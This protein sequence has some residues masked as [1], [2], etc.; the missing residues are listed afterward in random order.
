MPCCVLVSKP[1]TLLKTSCLKMTTVIPHGALCPCLS[2]ISSRP[3][4]PPYSR[5]RPI[6]IKFAMNDNV[7]AAPNLAS[8]AQPFEKQ[9]DRF[10]VKWV[11]LVVRPPA[12]VQPVNRQWCSESPGGRLTTAKVAGDME[13]RKESYFA[14]VALTARRRKEIAASIKTQSSCCVQ[15][16]QCQVSCSDKS[17][18]WLSKQYN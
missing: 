18:E 2:M 11:Y 7:V 14:L 12:A 8:Q 5:G 16:A 15:M 1:S 6:T 4:R 3:H 10:D 17:A 13:G 9:H